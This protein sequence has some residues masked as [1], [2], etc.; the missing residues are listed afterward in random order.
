MVDVD[1]RDV[2]LD[3]HEQ[4]FRLL[5]HL[6]RDLRGPWCLVGGLMVVVAGKVEGA[7]DERSLRTKDGDVVV[8]VV[9][10]PDMLRAARDRIEHYGF[11]VPPE[12]R[13]ESGAARCTFVEGR[14]QVDLLGPDDAPE[15]QLDLGDGFV[16]LAIPGGRRALE[17]ARAA[18]VRYSDEYPDAELMVPLGVDAVMVKAS[19]STDPRT[20]EQPRHIQDVAFLLAAASDP[21]AFRD[22][23][24]PD[25]E[26]LSRIEPRLRDEADAAWS[27]LDGE[28]RRRALASLRFALA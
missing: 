23:S 1:I 5:N 17:T 9:T 11:R 27:Y 3:R 18:T 12:A 14:A 22:L 21:R 25:C 20:A 26:L 15:D 10:N 7:V 19:A 2:V 6:G 16:S 4:V 24:D 8:D 28:S 13:R